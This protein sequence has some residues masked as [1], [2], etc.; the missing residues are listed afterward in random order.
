MA[1]NRGLVSWIIIA[2][3]IVVG[4]AVG[5]SIWNSL[6]DARA[7]LKAQAE[8]MKELEQRDAALNRYLDSLNVV[9]AEVRAHEAELAAQRDDLKKRLEKLQQDYNRAIGRLDKLWEAK[10]VIHELDGAFPNWAGQFFAATRHDGVHGLIAPQFFHAEVLEI[11][12][13]LDTRQQEV[14]LKDST[15]RSFEK[16]MTLKD[17][18]IRIITLQADS[19]RSTY[20]NLFAEYQA[21][22]EKYRKEVKSHWFKFSLGNAVYTGLGFGAGFLVGNATK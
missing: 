9:L 19:L 17:E 5:W 14:A 3:L 2:I 7:K 18:E 4:V 22:D 6:Q 15:I 1:A 10:E 8:K 13:E 11:K 12:T 21:L 16:S 20:N